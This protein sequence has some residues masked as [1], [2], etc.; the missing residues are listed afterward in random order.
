SCTLRYDFGPVA[1][2]AVSTY[3]DRDKIAM[4][5]VSDNFN[6]RN[7][8]A[9][10]AQYLLRDSTATCSASDLASYLDLTNTIL[11]SSLYHVKRRSKGTP[12][13]RRRGTP[14]SDMMLVC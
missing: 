1:L 4:G 11:F 3:F 12:D 5:D 14:F 6:G 7:T 10:C 9:G 13:R 2:T 8:A